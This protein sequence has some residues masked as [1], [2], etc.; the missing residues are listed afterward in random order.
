[1]WYEGTVFILKVGVSVISVAALLF[2]SSPSIR[3]TLQ[4]GLLKRC[5]PVWRR[6]QPLCWRSVLWQQETCWHCFTV[7][8]GSEAGIL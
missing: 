4:T 2:L 1:M 8:S 5:T 6:T 3:T 7:L